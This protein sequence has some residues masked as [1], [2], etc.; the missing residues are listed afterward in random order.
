MRIAGRSWSCS[1]SLMLSHCRGPSRWWLEVAAVR[2]HHRRPAPL[3]GAKL[4]YGDRSARQVGFVV[5]MGESDGHADRRQP[6]KRGDR[7]GSRH[8]SED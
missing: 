4:R 3:V 7:H 2:Q 6:S 1:G 5:S 8:I